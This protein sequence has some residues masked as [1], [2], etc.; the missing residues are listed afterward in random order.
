MFAILFTTRFSVSSLFL[1]S[2]RSFADFAK[3]AT[4]FKDRYFEDHPSRANQSDDS[5]DE[6]E[7]S[8]GSND[9]KGR[10]SRD[11]IGGNDGEKKERKER[12]D[13]LTHRDVEM[14]Y[15]KIVEHRYNGHSPKFA[16]SKSDRPSKPFE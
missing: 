12:K 6:D 7:E 13:T 16:F 15:W 4:L 10:N 5:D 8:D 1:L 11:S 9:N 14:A 3:L 2:Q